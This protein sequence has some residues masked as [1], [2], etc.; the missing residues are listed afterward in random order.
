MTSIKKYFIQLGILSVLFFLGLLSLTQIDKD[1]GAGVPHIDPI[2]DERGKSE[3]DSLTKDKGYIGH[4][5]A[6]RRQHRKLRMG[7]LD[8]E[9]V[10]ENFHQARAVHQLR[11]GHASQVMLSS[12]LRGEIK[13]Y[14]NANRHNVHFIGRRAPILS[15][16]D[17]QCLLMSQTSRL[18]LD[19]KEEPFS[20]HGWETLVPDT[21]LQELYGENLKTCAVVS[22]AGA[23]L[24]SGLG[25]EIGEFVYRGWR[26]VC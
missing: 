4:K 10:F 20:S 24:N 12:R 9:N 7:R 11:W 21:P 25:K 15:R 8:P 5:R 2:H 16:H 18:T 26:T 6:L 19:G 1:Y 13:K 22:S 23:I 3:P 14:V 17:L